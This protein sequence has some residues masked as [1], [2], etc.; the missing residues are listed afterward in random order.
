[1]SFKLFGAVAVMLA[2]L[3][4]SL[5]LNAREARRSAQLSAI[6]DLLRFFRTRIDCYLSPVGEIFAAADKKTLEACGCN[7]AVT[8]F[9]GFI[10]SLDPPPPEEALCL[11]RSFSAELGSSYREDQLKSCDYHLSRLI[12][13][14]DTAAAEAAKRRR[15]NTALCLTLAAATVILL[16]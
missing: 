15:L 3:G 14:R 4:L 6:C 7:T 1:M 9:D 12:P 13:I 16:I 5:V 2:G 10:E 11:L 8:S